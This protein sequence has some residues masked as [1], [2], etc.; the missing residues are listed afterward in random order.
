MPLTQVKLSADPRTL[1]DSQGS[2]AEVASL[3]ADPTRAEMLLAMMDGRAYPAS[4]LAAFAHV[5]A[6][7]ASHHLGMLVQGGLV[8]VITQGRHRYHRLA[9]AHVAEIIE[10]LGA[11]RIES[12]RKRVCPSRAGKLAHCRTCYDHLAGRLG[13][14]V[15]SSLEGLG[16]IE[17][18]GDRYAVTDKGVQFFSE[19]GID[20]DDCRRPG[21]PLAKACLDWT[22]R[23]PHIGSTLGRA[24]LDRMLD[25]R[26][27]ARAIVPRLL[28]VTPVGKER[29][30]V[31]FGIRREIC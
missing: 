2:L 17:L 21:R 20:V 27:L 30:E 10:S 29:L 14:E 15:R 1:M 28:V 13:V 4:E 7:T 22:E 3:F 18:D 8:A 23:L 25:R 24:L 11:L 12:N 19:F 16:C 26:W 5:S 6:P 31:V 9:S